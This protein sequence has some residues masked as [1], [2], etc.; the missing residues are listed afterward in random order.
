MSIGAVIVA[1]GMSSR[2]GDYKPMLNLGNISIAQRVITALQQGGVDKIVVVTG[3]RA[4]ELEH[5][6]SKCGA[7]FLRNEKYET[8]DMFFSAS[9]GLSYLKDKCEKVLFTPVDIPLFS[10]VTVSALLSCNTPLAYPSYRGITGHPI[11]LTQEVI[12]KILDDSGDG[13]LK[14]ALERCGIAPTMVD[15]DDSG[16]LQDADT[17]E[18]FAALLQ[19]HNR[20][21]VRPVIEVSL[22][23]Q[24]TFFNKK[25]AM[26]L[27][28]VAETHSVLLACKQM[29]ISYSS[30]W[31]LLNAIEE[32]L[33]FALVQRV[34][35]GTK[36]GGSTLTEAG[37]KLLSAYTAYS[38]SLKKVGEDL[39]HQY[40]G[41]Y[42]P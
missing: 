25:A 14:G 27:T 12:D 1:A 9:L 22:A 26:L 13:G 3:Y 39:F 41:D 11:L 34:Q 28:L 5:H 18:D 36:G 32:E 29:R 40:F 7:V 20:M 19:L 38:N 10:P 33:G 6:L 30:G 8:T 21:L 2:M 17:P 37:R 42:L 4:E 35:G 15:V 16:I 23:Q 24:Q 31:N